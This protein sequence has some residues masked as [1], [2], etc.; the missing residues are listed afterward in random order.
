MTFPQNPSQY[1]DLDDYLQRELEKLQQ[2]EE[3]ECSVTPSASPVSVAEDAA[4]KPQH[5]N[6]PSAKHKENKKI[7]TCTFGDCRKHYVKSSH[8]KVKYMQ[9]KVQS[10]KVQ[11]KP[12]W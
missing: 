7:F 10:T 11:N 4:S 8:L 5:K 9:R 3:A 2:E 1:C 12:F 6:K